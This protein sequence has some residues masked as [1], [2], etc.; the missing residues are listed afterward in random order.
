MDL[1]QLVRQAARGEVDAFVDL[2]HGVFSTSPS[3]RRSHWVQEAFVAAWSALPSRRLSQAGCAV[4]CRTMPSA[5]CATGSY[6][7]LSEALRTCREILD[8]RHDDVPVE[9]FYFAA[10]IAEIRYS[11][12]VRKVPWQAANA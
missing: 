3:A 6:V 1:E 4:S 11:R 7:G 12:P 10:N 8:G 9:V 5:C 2:T